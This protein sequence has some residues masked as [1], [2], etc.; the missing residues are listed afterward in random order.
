MTIIL[1]ITL[2]SVQIIFI[3]TSSSLSIVLEQTL[4]HEKFVD[5]ELGRLEARN[6]NKEEARR[7][8]ELVLSGKVLGVNWNGRKGELL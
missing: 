3:S 2:V 4:T 7:H 6:G 8:I 1:F 5:Y